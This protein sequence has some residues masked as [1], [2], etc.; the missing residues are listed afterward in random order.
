MADN[1]TLNSGS[2]GSTLRTDDDGSAHWQYTKLA[3][4]ADNT[5]TIVGSISSNP[6]PVALSAT[7]N[8]VLD[9]INTAVELI[10]DAIYVDDADW[11][12]ST[13]K[14]MLIG[15]VYQSSPQTITSG[16]VGPLQVTANGY[17]IVS[18][19]GTVT[20][21]SHAVTNAG[22]FAVQVDG[23]A[24]TALQLIDDAIYV[25]DADWTD[26][27]SKHMLIGGV[28]QSSPQTITSGDVGP[29]Q[30]TANGYA[31]VSVNGTVTVGSHA[32]TNAGTFAVQ[33]TLEA[34]SGTDIGD[35]D[36]L[37][38]V[39]GTGATNLGKAEDASHSSGDT[40][41]M[42]L[43]VRKNT[44]AATS[45][46]DGDYQPLITDTNGRLHVNDVNTAAAISGS[47]LQVD[48]VASLP[49]GTNAIGKLAANSG[50][51]IGDT[52]VLSIIAGTGATNLGKA[53]D[54]AAGGTD[55]GVAMLAVR[56]DEKAALVADGDYI[57]PRADRFGALR[58]TG[59][60]DATSEIKYA[61]VDAAS[62]GNN[63]LIAAAGGG[64]KI[65]VLSVFMI[66]AG[67]CTARFENGAGGTA[68]TGQMSL[69]ANSGFVL[70]Y[71]EGGWFE[72]SDNTLLN[73]EL[74]AGVSVDGSFSYVEV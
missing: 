39:A 6:L 29:L 7:D 37:S 14:H 38:I 45:G 55:T 50:V 46:A 57:V 74:S 19:N 40:G 68:L 21:G 32:V 59:L 67:T 41:V 64:I 26:S 4:G 42:S 43:S 24:L 53:V 30:V 1:I 54:S 8:A 62:S 72:T 15:G 28:Y 34:N 36:V 23:S 51:D 10:D 58:V 48:V 11:T 3:F 5:Q 35:V 31:I 16:D 61:K 25:D 12:D 69:V 70:P 20:V 71:N 2:G 66:S 63:T 27:T 60:P 18:V 73:L 44:A 52:D 56:D 22:T 47:E 65:R 9:T 17:A 49:A 13:S 33:S